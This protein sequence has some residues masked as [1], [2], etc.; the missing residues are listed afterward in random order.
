MQHDQAR[1]ADATR[2]VVGKGERHDEV[3]GE[4]DDGRSCGDAF[5]CAGM[6]VERGRQAQE[7]LDIEAACEALAVR[8]EP[9]EHAIGRRGVTKAR[10]EFAGRAVGQHGQSTRAVQRLLERLGARM[11][12][13][14]TPHMMRHSAATMMV[15]AGIPL[16]D[17]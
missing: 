8:V 3:F 17:V 15:G 13:H 11:G 1:T 12:R 9:A 10:F 2:A 16:P 5:D 6:R 14:L 7:G 4:G